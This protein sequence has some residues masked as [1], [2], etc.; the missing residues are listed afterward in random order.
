VVLSFWYSGCVP[1]RKMIPDEKALVKRMEGK[2]FVLLG[3][4]NDQDRDK[5]K[6]LVAKE[7]MS[8]RSWYD[9]GTG[10]PIADRWVVE[11]WPTVF[12][13]DHKGVVRNKGE[14]LMKARW[15]IWRRRGICRRKNYQSTE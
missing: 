6:A 7:G 5:A 12:V 13:L 3:V 11:G 10:G 9:L 4:N 2:P 14:C 15:V 1:C 8:W